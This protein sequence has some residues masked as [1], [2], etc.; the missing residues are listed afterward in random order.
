M[1]TRAAAEHRAVIDA[2]DRRP[3]GATV[4]VT[5]HVGRLNMPCA[6]AR[7]RRAVMTTRTTTEYRA[8]ID[9]RDRRPTAGAVTAGA[10]VDVWI[11]RVPFPGAATPL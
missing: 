1:A 3:T 2:R 4:A 10:G 7:R 11:W 9:A 5:A 8:V 6:L